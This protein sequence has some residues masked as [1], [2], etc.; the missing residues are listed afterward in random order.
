[1]LSPS[2]TAAAAGEIVAPVMPTSTG[3]PKLAPLS[4]E[5]HMIIGWLSG[6]GAPSS[7]ESTATMPAAGSTTSGLLSSTAPGCSAVSETVCEHARFPRGMVQLVTALLDVRNTACAVPVV[8]TATLEEWFTPWAT[9][10][11]V[12][13]LEALG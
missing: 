8:S 2:T 4:C 9:M 7:L 1:M 11:P 5:T 12:A 6:A 13:Y 10:K 3:A